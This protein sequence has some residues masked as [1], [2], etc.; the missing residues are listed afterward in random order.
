MRWFQI[1]IP[2][3]LRQNFKKH[4]F[5][6]DLNNSLYNRKRYPLT[7]WC[8]PVEGNQTFTN[9]VYLRSKQKYRI[10]QIVIFKI[11]LSVLSSSIFNLGVHS[12]CDSKHLPFVKSTYAQPNTHML[13]VM[14]TQVVVTSQWPWKPYC[15]LKQLIKYG[16]I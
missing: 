2:K 5:R 14:I 4:Y 13:V 6:F 16:V 1:D 15:K 10:F 12:W 11:L 9:T 8:Y 7:Y 3:G